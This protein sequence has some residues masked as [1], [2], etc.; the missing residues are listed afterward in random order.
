MLFWLIVV[1][2][3]SLSIGFVMGATFRQYKRP[4]SIDVTALPDDA[5]DFE[6]AVDWVARD[7]FFT[8]AGARKAYRR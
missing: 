4:R 2:V 7:K 5:T 1:A 3:V 6:I 8:A